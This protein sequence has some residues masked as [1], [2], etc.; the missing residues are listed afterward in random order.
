MANYCFPFVV[1]GL[2]CKFSPP[3]HPSKAWNIYRYSVHRQSAFC[4]LKL[5]LAHLLSG[6]V[7]GVSLAR[8][9]VSLDKQLYSNLSLF[10]QVY[11]W[12]PATYFWGVTLWWTSI[13]SRGG[14]AILIGL[15]HS[16]ET[17]NKLLPCGPLARVRLYLTSINFL[18]SSIIET[19]I[20]K[21]TIPN[22]FHDVRKET[23]FIHVTGKGKREMAGKSRGHSLPFAFA[24]NAFTVL[25]VFSLSFPFFQRFCSHS[26]LSCGNHW[27]QRGFIFWI[28]PEGN[29]FYTAVLST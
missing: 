17:R 12:V 19:V 3:C 5:L 24:V 9:V 15:L 2:V 26:W 22:V 28:S 29:T 18:M 6:G 23:V 20:L 8:R 14:V 11:K 7:C 1:C 4:E 10:T 25:S 21:H 27:Q 13:P 16:T